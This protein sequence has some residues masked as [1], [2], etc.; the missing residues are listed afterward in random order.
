MSQERESTNLTPVLEIGGTHATAALV[1]LPRREIVERH[2]VD[3]D[4]RAERAHLVASLVATANMLTHVGSRRWGIAIPGPFDYRRGVGDFRGVGKFEALRGVNLGSVLSKALGN[5]LLQVAFVND[6]DASAIGEW[7]LRGS[8]PRRSLVLTL[9]TGVG[10]SFLVDG[11]PQRV[12]RGVP[13][14]GFVCNLTVDGL[15]LESVISRSALVGAYMSATGEFIDVKAIAERA[16]AGDRIA[17]EVF[18]RGFFLLGRALGPAVDG[19]G[20]QVVVIGGSIAKSWDLIEPPFVEGLTAA[21]FA[22]PLPRLELACEG[23]KGA[24]IGAALATTAAH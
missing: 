16:R 12:G 20:P 7:Y 3:I 15:P 21:T 9:G 14:C 17:I 19:F 8:S 13:A 18:N 6:A 10:S 11:V 23:E 1:S 5:S 22:T 24:L 2:R 4:P